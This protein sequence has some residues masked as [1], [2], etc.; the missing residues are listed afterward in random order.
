MHCADCVEMLLQFSMIKL[1]VSVHVLVVEP[2][3]RISLASYSDLQCHAHDQSFWVVF[4]T[5]LT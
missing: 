2:T 4:I 3:G 5:F 1:S